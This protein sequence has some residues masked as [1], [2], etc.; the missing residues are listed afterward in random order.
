MPQYVSGNNVKAFTVQTQGENLSGRRRA[1]LLGDFAESIARNLV[2]IASLEP[3]HADQVAVE[4]VDKVA[5]EFGGEVFY[6]PQGRVEKNRSVRDVEIYRRKLAGEGA[7]DLAREYK[8]SRVRIFQ[9]VNQC[10]EQDE[11]AAAALAKQKEIEQGRRNAGDKRRLQA[12]QRAGAEQR[13]LDEQRAGEKPIH[14]W[15]V[16]EGA[17]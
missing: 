16:R 12:D 7:D 9:I 2:S 5:E 10:R 15:K 14:P 13:K 17:V 11:R 1:E 8:L 3:A 4:V 6:L